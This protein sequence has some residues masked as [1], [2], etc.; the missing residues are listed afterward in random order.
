MVIDYVEKR[1]KVLFRNFS[2]QQEFKRYTM[3]EKLEC[4][5]LVSTFDARL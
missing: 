2:N 5:N 1:I 3:L 4:E